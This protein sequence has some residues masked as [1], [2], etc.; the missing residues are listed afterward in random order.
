MARNLGILARQFL[1]NRRKPGA[2]LLHHRLK[3]PFNCVQSQSQS[4][5]RTT[6]TLTGSTPTAPSST[7][8]KKVISFNFPDLR[9]NYRLLEKTRPDKATGPS[10]TILKAPVDLMDKLCSVRNEHKSAIFYITSSSCEASHKLLSPVILELSGRFLHVRVYKLILPEYDV[11]DK[12][13]PFNLINLPNITFFQYGDKAA[14]IFGVDITGLKQTFEK[15]FSLDDD[16][17]EESNITET[18]Q[19]SKC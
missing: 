11:G 13:G 4:Q 1:W 6:Q 18:T 9:P 7:N 12:V 2:D 8:T 3:G 14:E 5:S 15:L 19:P 10:N 17:L 16:D